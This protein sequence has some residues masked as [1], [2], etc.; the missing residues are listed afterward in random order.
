MYT[1]LPCHYS[2]QVVSNGLG[3]GNDKPEVL[4][5]QFVQKFQNISRIMDCVGCEKCKLWG[6]LEIL[7]IGTVSVKSH[8]LLNYYSLILHNIRILLN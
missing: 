3:D 2:R 5:E 4:R 1:L 7:G 6:K 8:F